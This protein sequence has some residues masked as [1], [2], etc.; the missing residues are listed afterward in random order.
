M[1]I[2]VEVFIEHIDELTTNRQLYNNTFTDF[3]KSNETV[4]IVN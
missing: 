4:H 1:K 3:R 2:F